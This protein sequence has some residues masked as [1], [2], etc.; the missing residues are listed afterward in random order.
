M[1]SGLP[2]D[3]NA[4]NIPILPFIDAL[5]DRGRLSE[6]NSMGYAS[7][8]PQRPHRHI[9]DDGSAAGLSAVIGRKEHFQSTTM[10]RKKVHGYRV[11]AVVSLPNETA[12]LAA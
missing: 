12:V 5:V 2:V 8:P 1:A 4:D 9:P 3:D 7:L 11:P 10:R 6:R